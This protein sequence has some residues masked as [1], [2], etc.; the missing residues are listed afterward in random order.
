[1]NLVGTQKTSMP[2]VMQT[3]M[4]RLLRFQMGRVTVLGIRVDTT[5]VTF[6]QRICPG[7]VLVLSL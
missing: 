3:V 1:M 7:S 4:D 5:D 6:C 2:I